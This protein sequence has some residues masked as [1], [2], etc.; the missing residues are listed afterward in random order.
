MTRRRMVAVL[1][2]VCG[3]LWARPVNAQSQ[4]APH[5]L[6]LVL[7]GVDGII[8]TYRGQKQIIT[9]SEIMNALATKESK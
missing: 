2:G 8:V 3:Y 1:A 7:D 5:G 9:P 4:Q 6:N